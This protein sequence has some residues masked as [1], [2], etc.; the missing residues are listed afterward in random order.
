MNTVYY[1]LKLFILR[2]YTV[3]SQGR[4]NHWANRANARGLALLRASRLNIKTFF[5]WFFM[6]VGCSPRIKIV[7]LF[8]YCVNIRV[9]ETDNLA[10]IVV[11]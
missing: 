4:I 11:E 9:E 2:F 8:D 3:Y 10:F 1:L 6:F 5:Y 7:E